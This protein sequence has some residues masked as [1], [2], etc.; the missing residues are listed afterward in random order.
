MD[1][2]L[3]QKIPIKK[4]P[5][6]QAQFTTIQVS[7]MSKKGRKVPFLRPF[8]EMTSLR[9]F[10]GNFLTSFLLRY[11]HQIC[12]DYRLDQGEF[13]EVKIMNFDDVAKL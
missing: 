3:I 8:L 6:P 7:A 5:D 9:H 13:C 12:R 1:G 4:A 2:P 10:T 11:Q